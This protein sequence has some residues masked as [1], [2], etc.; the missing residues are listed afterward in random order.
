M[1]PLSAAPLPRQRPPYCS[2]AWRLTQNLKGADA[3]HGRRHPLQPCKQPAAA[4]AAAATAT[5]ATAATPAVAV[6]AVSSATSAA[7]PSGEA[8]MSPLLP[9]L[10][11][12]S[13]PPRR[14]AIPHG[15]MP[16]TGAEAA[17][18]AATTRAVRQAAGAA[19]V[20]AKRNWTWTLRGQVWRGV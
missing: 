14:G 16:D 15:V 6:T 18:C 4:A 1:L 9:P 5:A 20:G 3:I 17:A 19:D 13:P 11:P 12:P 8:D 7:A 2:V 10:P